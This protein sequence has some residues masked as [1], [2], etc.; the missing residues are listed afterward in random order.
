M[1][2]GCRSQAL[3]VSLTTAGSI[4]AKKASARPI[5][6]SNSTCASNSSWLFAG[7]SSL[8]LQRIYAGERK[9]LSRPGEGHNLN[10]VIFGGDHW[11]GF[12][13]VLLHASQP[14]G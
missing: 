4:L 13:V 6:K 9:S 11:R 10:A 7:S 1:L 8:T 5:A 12:N 14:E 3:G 2:S